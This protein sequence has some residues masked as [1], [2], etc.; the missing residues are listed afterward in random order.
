MEVFVRNLRDEATEKQVK[1]FFQPI[2]ASLSIDV[3]HC[4]K[5]RNRGFAKI[6]ICDVQLGHKFLDLHGQILAGRIG[7]NAVRQKLYHYGKPVNCT[8]SHNSPDPFIIKSLERERIEKSGGRRPLVKYTPAGEKRRQREF[9]G[10]LV[11]VGSMDYSGSD[12]IF[13]NSIQLE[14]RTSIRFGRRSVLVEF[15]EEPIQ[16]MEI[17]YSSIQSLLLGS[18]ASPCVIFSLVEAPR[19]FLKELDT[20]DG[21][22]H[23]LGR[24]SLQPPKGQRKPPQRR[25]ITAMDAAHQ[26]IVASNLCYGFQVNPSDIQAI[27]A[28][29]RLPG[30][31]DVVA[32]QV[33]FRAKSPFP[34]Q[35]T[36]LNTDLSAARYK[37]FPFEVKFQLQRLA[38]NGYLPPYK[39]SRLMQAMKK[40]FSSVDNLLLSRALRRLSNHIPYAGPGIESSELSHDALHELLVD[41][42]H[43]TMREKEYSKDVTQQYEHIASVF[44]A[45]VTPAGIYLYG[46]E[47]E[48]KNRVLRQYS[49]FSSYFLQ[50]S[51]LDE[52]G[53]SL[54]YER[55][56]SL[57]TIYHERF[58]KVLAGNITIAGRPYEVL[59]R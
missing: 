17:P 28:L 38:Q 10:F 30:L 41:D 47:P 56:V 36:R 35:M 55:G 14:R 31:P 16:Q 23:S 32:W 22:T 37:M 44:K 43:H 53:E 29:K 59:S 19:F 24:M 18:S 34:E 12:L 45:T 54:R 21:L 1:Q 25:R 27:I 9:N 15:R 8:R 58:K 50:V 26:A 5:P 20:E 7:F 42:Y 40:T 2:L 49:A 33:D 3:F 46:P 52:D 6:T 39:V 13:A 48:I 4:Q 11:A 51:F 57:Q